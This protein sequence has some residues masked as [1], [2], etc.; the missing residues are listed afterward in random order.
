MSYDATNP[1][2]CPTCDAA[3]IDPFSE[4]AEATRDPA[5]VCLLAELSDRWATHERGAIGLHL[6]YLSVGASNYFIRGP[7]L[8]ALGLLRRAHAGEVIAAEDWAAAAAACRHAAQDM[9]RHFLAVPVASSRQ[10]LTPVRAAQHAAYAAAF[11]CSDDD[12]A[13][14]AYNAIMAI[15]H[16]NSDTTGQ[17]DGAVERFV[18]DVAT[19][20]GAS[21]RP[22]DRLASSSRA[23]ARGRRARGR[24][25]TRACRR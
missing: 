4:M 14:C 17:R 9:P 10:W 11:G 8:P 1:D 20:I 22:D 25:G 19:R 7:D 18:V 5:A 24:R 16:A 3:A 21:P 6:R 13:R 12:A 2:H 15:A 23:K